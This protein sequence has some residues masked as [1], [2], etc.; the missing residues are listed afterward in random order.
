MSCKCRHGQV[1]SALRHSHPQ[2]C[3]ATFTRPQHVGRHLRAHTG[4]RPY[5][6]KE[7]PLRFAR[8]DLLSRH[9]NKAHPKP[10][11]H[12]GDKGKDKRGR[13]K[14]VSTQNPATGGISASRPPQHPPAAPQ[15]LVHPGHP[16]VHAA[17]QA[18]RMY[19]NHPLLQQ[20]ANNAQL[21]VQPTF[22]L[23]HGNQFGTDAM[24]NLVMPASFGPMG[25]D[26]VNPHASF[27]PQL[28]QAAPHMGLDLAVKKR[29]CDQCNHSKVRCDCAEP[30]GE[31][32]LEETSVCVDR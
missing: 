24:G 17:F 10:D 22:T 27:D 15:P 26:P 31:F 32:L 2:L 30:C 25:P 12:G 29:A 1:G 9:V 28:A 23:G 7:C 14:S 19:P 16:P 21:W 6:C 18:Q 3:S 20:N 13:R 5:E 11:G 8:S 4:D